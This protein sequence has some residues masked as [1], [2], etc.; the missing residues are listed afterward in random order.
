MNLLRTSKAHHI[1]T[2]S[3]LKLQYTYLRT[4]PKL[5][6]P[7]F[8][9]SMA[10][11]VLD[12]KLHTHFAIFLYALRLETVMLTKRVHLDAADAE[13]SVKFLGTTSL[14][15]RSFSARQFQT[16]TLTFDQPTEA[17]RTPGSTITVREG[18]RTRWSTNQVQLCMG[19]LSRGNI[20]YRNIN[21]AL[22]FDQIKCPPGPTRRRSTPLRHF[23]HL[24]RAKTR[25]FILPGTGK[26]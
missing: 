26:L 12:T 7:L 1:A 21:T 16:S 19:K 24:T 20:R 14:S 6:A 9:V 23:P 13:R 22:G 11:N 18:R 17:R 4:D 3:I 15:F 8:L 5:W 25:M 2:S 10:G